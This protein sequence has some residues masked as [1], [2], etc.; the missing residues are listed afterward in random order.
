MYNY[1]NYYTL[2]LLWKIRLVESKII[3]VIVCV[4][5]FSD[6][7]SDS[8]WSLWES[9]RGRLFKIKWSSTRIGPDSATAKCIHCIPMPPRNC[10]KRRGRTTV[11]FMIS[12]FIHVLWTSV[13]HFDKK[14]SLIKIL[15]NLID[16]K[17]ENAKIFPTHSRAGRSERNLLVLV[18]FFVYRFIVLCGITLTFFSSILFS[19]HDWLKGSLIYIQSLHYK[20]CKKVG[21]RTKRDAGRSFWPS[22]SRLRGQISQSFSGILLNLVSTTNLHQFGSKSR[23]VQWRETKMVYC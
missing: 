18:K 17:R 8:R 11:S 21:R 4:S 14:L 2:H 15:S 6:A 12:R 22:E 3:E 16:K 19:N 1:E 13:T 7:S 23:F 5:A 9:C 20:P 10:K